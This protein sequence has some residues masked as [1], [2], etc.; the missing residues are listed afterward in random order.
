MKKK[1]VVHKSRRFSTMDLNRWYS[2]HTYD[3]FEQAPI[4]NKNMNQWNNKQSYYWKHVN[5][6]RCKAKKEKEI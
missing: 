2:S 5:C 3:D 6:E 1:P 4:C